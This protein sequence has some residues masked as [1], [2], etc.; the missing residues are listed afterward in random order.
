M[1]Y[2][3]GAFDDLR[4]DVELAMIRAKNRDAERRANKITDRGGA[5][6]VAL[7]GDTTFLA[8]DTV[9]D[10]TYQTMEDDE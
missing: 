3:C 4:N 2:P 7:T 9:D 10:V 8:I 5:L 6:M 1:K